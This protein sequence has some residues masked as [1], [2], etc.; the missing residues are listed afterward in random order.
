[1]SWIGV[2]EAETLMRLRDAAPRA[3]EAM[4]FEL[5]GVRA[6]ERERESVVNLWCNAA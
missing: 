2:L 1:M 4:A 5:D 6:S 3:R